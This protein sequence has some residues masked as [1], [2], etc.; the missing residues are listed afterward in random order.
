MTPL[1]E[2]DSLG[3]MEKLKVRPED[4]AKHDEYL[5]AGNALDAYHDGALSTGNPEYRYEK[6]RKEWF[7][8]ESWKNRPPLRHPDTGRIIG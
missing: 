1:S 6:A 2:A 4:Q 8:T 3:G 5:A 7:A